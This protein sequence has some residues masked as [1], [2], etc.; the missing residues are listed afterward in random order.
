MLPE[1]TLM[2]PIIEEKEFQ[3]SELSFSENPKNALTGVALSEEQSLSR[4]NPTLPA[5]L[6]S[7]SKKDDG[8]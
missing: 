1:D 3:S 8:L 5:P 6:Q 4:S 2:P 7:S